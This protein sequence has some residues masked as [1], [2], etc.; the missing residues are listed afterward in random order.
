MIILYIL[1]CN[2]LCCKPWKWKSSLWE[3]WLDHRRITLKSRKT[4]QSNKGFFMGTTQRVTRNYFIQMSTI[5]ALSTNVSCYEQVH[6][7]MSIAL[8]PSFFWL[9]KIEAKEHCLLQCAPI[10]LQ[11]VNIV[12]F[13]YSSLLF[14]DGIREISLKISLRYRRWVAQSVFFMVWLISDITLT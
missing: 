8:T 4:S 9:K 12:S 2:I 3:R 7:A 13:T 1:F 10:Q 11:H 14:H 5:A 6:Y